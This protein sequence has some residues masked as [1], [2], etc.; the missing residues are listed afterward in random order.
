MK[1]YLVKQPNLYAIERESEKYYLL[2]RRGKR[3]ACDLALL[4]GYYRDAAVITAGSLEEVFEEG[5]HKDYN[6]NIKKLN[7]FHS[8]SVGDI[9][10]D[11]GAEESF[12]VA[13][14]GFEKL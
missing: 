9:I 10:V 5:N 4:D 13:P 6:E 14:I 11:L 8:V 7:E 3:H 2:V 12:V 1:K